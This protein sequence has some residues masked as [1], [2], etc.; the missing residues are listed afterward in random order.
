MNTSLAQAAL[1][2]STGNKLSPRTLAPV[3]TPTEVGYSNAGSERAQQ[4]VALNQAAT[5][6]NQNLNTAASQ[7]QAKFSGQE[8]AQLSAENTDAYRYGQAAIAFRNNFL[9]KSG[10]ISPDGPVAAMGSM[11]GDQEAALL[12]TIRSLSPGTNTGNLG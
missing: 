1:N 8:K 2:I 11:S 7:S 6:N 12:N 9:E 10:L 3:G 4:Y 5:R